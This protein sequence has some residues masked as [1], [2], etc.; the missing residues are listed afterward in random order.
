VCSDRLAKTVR[1]QRIQGLQNGI[2]YEFAVVAIDKVGNASAVTEA[3]LTY[4]TGDEDLWQHY[5]DLGGGATGGF[6]EALPGAPAL[7]TLG[8]GIVAIGAALILR[9]RR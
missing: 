7:A 8:L 6:C 5:H 2:P 9:R 3:R 4:P 1:T